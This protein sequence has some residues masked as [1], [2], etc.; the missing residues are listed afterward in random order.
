MSCEISCNNEN[1]ITKRT[2][3]R[4]ESHQVE[5][6]FYCY[7]PVVTPKRVNGVPQGWVL[8]PRLFPDYKG[9][10]V[11]PWTVENFITYVLL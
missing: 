6:H 2:Q 8:V 9:Q 4:Q 5:E 1:Y 11:A 10:R 3:K 7:C